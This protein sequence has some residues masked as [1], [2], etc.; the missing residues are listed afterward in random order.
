MRAS[1][2]A[3]N[4]GERDTSR[5]VATSVLIRKRVGAGHA[6]R[7]GLPNR[8]RRLSTYHTCGGRRSSAST[9]SRAIRSF[10]DALRCRRVPTRWLHRPR[11]KSTVPITT[12]GCFSRQV[13]GHR[14]VWGQKIRDLLDRP[15]V[16]C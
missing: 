2:T 6:Q 10:G 12:S 1:V 16:Q 8:S 13:P 7:H 15:F 11:W 14:Q 4:A 9:R 3:M 5:S